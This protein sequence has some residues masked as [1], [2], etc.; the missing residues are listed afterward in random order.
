[1]KII[2]SESRLKNIVKKFMMDRLGSFGKELSK[3]RRNLGYIGS[4][5]TS[6]GEKTA[7]VHMDRFEIDTDLYNLM[8]DMFVVGRNYLELEKIILDTINERFPEYNI[9]AIRK[10]AYHRPPF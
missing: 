2:I 7:D 9:K 6:E 5:Y 1:M 3:F 4:F 8:E 10:V